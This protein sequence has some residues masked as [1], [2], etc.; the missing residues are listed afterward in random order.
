MLYHL[1]RLST[2][3]TMDEGLVYRAALKTYHGAPWVQLPERGFQ[4][5]KIRLSDI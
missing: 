3:L 5:G 1:T 2:N 4:F